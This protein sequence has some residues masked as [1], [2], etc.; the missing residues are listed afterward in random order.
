MRANSSRDRTFVVGVDKIMNKEVALAINAVN[1]AAAVLAYKRKSKSSPARELNSAFWNK[2]KPAEDEVEILAPKLP[3]GF[4][5]PNWL[6][7]E[8]EKNESLNKEAAKE[9]DLLRKK[10]KK[11][12]STGFE[13]EAEEAEDDDEIAVKDEDLIESEEAA[14]A[15]EPAA[16]KPKTVNKTVKV[17]DEKA[18]I[19][20]EFDDFVKNPL[21]TDVQSKVFNAIEKYIDT[22]TKV[23]K[24]KEEK[25]KKEAEAEKEA[26]AA[27]A[28]DLAK[29]PMGLE[30]D[31]SEERRTM[32]SVE[33]T[34]KYFQRHGR[35]P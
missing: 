2:K 16:E 30:L 34:F 35:L 24:A 6:Q 21:D 15:V 29:N 3:E 17:Q 18:A 12:E 9:I 5:P 33:A 13:A 26:A 1:E 32:A 10:I 20:K 27:K 28:A 22:M 31:L 19:A 11:G 4:N 7:E 14:P 25:E 23:K 8:L